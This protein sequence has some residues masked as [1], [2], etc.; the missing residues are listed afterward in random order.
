MRFTYLSWG[1]PRVFTGSFH[2][3]IIF[4]LFIEANLFARRFAKKTLEQSGTPLRSNGERRHDVE[5]KSCVLAH[6]VGQTSHVEHG[7][8]AE[9]D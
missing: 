4:T 5:P 9:W 2:F 3:V 1:Q 7:E 8:V 6:D